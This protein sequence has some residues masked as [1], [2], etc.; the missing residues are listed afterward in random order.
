MT[1]SKVFFNAYLTANAN[2]DGGIFSDYISTDQD[3]KAICHS[4]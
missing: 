4:L 2:L 3:F 1:P